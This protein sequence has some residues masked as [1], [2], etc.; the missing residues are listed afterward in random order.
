MELAPGV[1]PRQAAYQA[2]RLPLHHASNVAVCS[3]LT[4]IT[5]LTGAE[6]LRVLSGATSGTRTLST[7]LG[8]PVA[9]SYTNVAHRWWG[10]VDLNHDGMVTNRRVTA[11]CLSVEANPPYY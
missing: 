1:E 4:S 10:V 8:R 9:T 7:R 11:G 6:D 5:S 2:A 3:M